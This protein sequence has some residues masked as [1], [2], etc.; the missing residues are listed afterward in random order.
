[1]IVGICQPNF[2][3]WIGYFVHIASVDTFVF[4]DDVQ[5]IKREWQNRNKLPTRQRDSWHWLTI[6]VVRAPQ[7]TLISEVELSGIEDWVRTFEKTILHT[8][9]RSALESAI[10][11]SVTRAI[12]SNIL[13]AEVNIALIRDF[14]SILDIETK[15]LRSSSIE[16][17]EYLG[18]TE[19]L[20]SICS[21]VGGDLYYANP[22]S[23]GYIKA[24]A[25][26]SVGIGFEF[27]DF[28]KIMQFEVDDELPSLS[29]LD[30]LLSTENFKNE[31]WGLLK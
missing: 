27:F 23:K 6:P 11:R 30:F 31:F 3:P 12:R 26:Q 25:F 7:D 22:G 5:F 17:S 21:A 4:L 28:S 14:C 8:Y 2:L 9:G 16:K 20:V 13:L 10:M 19:R 24:E 29:I 1:M 15:L 18:K